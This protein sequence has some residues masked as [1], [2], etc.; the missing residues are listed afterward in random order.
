VPA[1][2]LVGLALAG[3]WMLTRGMTLGPGTT[4]AY[5]EELVHTV[6]PLQAGRLKEVRV[7]LGQAVKAGEVLAQLD[8]KPLELHRDRVK[9]ELLHAKAQLAA[10]TDLQ[11]A[12]LQRGQIQ[13]VRAHA[14]VQRLRAELSAYDQQVKRLKNLKSKQ[15]IRANDIEEAQRQQRSISAD[16]SARP[17]GSARDMELLGLRPRPKDEQ[18]RRLEE[19]LHPFRA[20]IAV[21]EAALA[22]LDYAIDQLTLRSPIDGLVGAI[23]QRAGDSLGAGTPVL[24]IV[25]TRPGHLVAFVPE[26]QM[27]AFQLG[28]AVELRK[29]GLVQIP[30]KGH[31]AQQAPMVEEVPIRVR[32]TPTV[33]LW[34]RRIVIK[35][36]EPTPLLPGEAFR[37]YSR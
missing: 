15:L 33:P 16:L 8:T 11:E 10:E 21:Q 37:V 19:R 25:T 23:L 12:M 24:T 2:V 18:L 32:P 13:A 17:K 20:A 22:E 28:G 29:I 6:G 30:L 14:S 27:K 9:T 35:L 36:D 34:G 26:R 5:A 7:V 4:M 3:F 31:V 1:W